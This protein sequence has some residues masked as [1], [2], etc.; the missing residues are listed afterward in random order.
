MNINIQK[1]LPEVNEI[2]Q[3]AGE[4]LLELQPRVRNIES[5]G[6]DFLTEADLKSHSL[7]SERLQR[8]TPEIPVYSEEGEKFDITQRGALWVVDPLDG[9]VNYFHQDVFWGV[10]I[11]LVENQRTQLGVVYLPSLNQLAGVAR[12]GDIVTKGNITLGV[13]SDTNL[14]WAQ[15]W[16]DWGKES[17]AAL[18][19][20]PK[21]KEVSLYPEI[22]LCCS[23]SLLAVASGRISG[24]IHPQ[25]APEDIAAGCLIVEKAG[26][27]ITDFKGND[28]APFS[29]SIIASNGLLHEQILEAIRR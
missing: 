17:K 20:L 2:I 10:S 24:Y 21:L 16:T 15:I 6:K 7:I 18:S 11:A 5:T 19:I 23:A 1:L 8:L 27:R 26:G 28:W 14:S 25:P 22:R 4:F 29:D 3:K 13:R 12:E 9:T